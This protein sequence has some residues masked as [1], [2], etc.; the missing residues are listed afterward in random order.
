MS[1]E[2]QANEATQAYDHV[3]GQVFDPIFF[4]KLAQA[5]VVPQT[6]REAE[7]LR[8]LGSHLYGLHQEKVAAE[9]AQHGTF[10]DQAIA[11]LHEVT[12]ATTSDARI[13]QASV[14]ALNDPALLAA[15][16]VLVPHV[17]AGAR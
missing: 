10:L 9:T 8:E 1:T 4:N 6:A 2:A 3:M 15:A 12:G 13:K 7:Q 16:L 14:A 17:M 5:G 11:H